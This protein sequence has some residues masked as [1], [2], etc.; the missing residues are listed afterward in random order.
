[1]N[2]GIGRS[3]ALILLLSTILA[4]CGAA[5]DALDDLLGGDDETAVVAD[6][7]LAEAID[8]IEAFWAEQGPLVELDYEPVDRDRIL[9]RSELDDIGPAECSFDGGTDDLTAES[10]ADNAYVIE[11][12]E[13]NTV[14]LDDVDYVPDLRARYG[15]AGP[16][17]LV[18]HE[19]G[20]VVQNQL[21]RTEQTSILAEQQAD[22]YSGAYI[23][24]AES[25]GRAPFDD[26]ASL[27]DAILSTIETADGEEVTASDEEAHGNGFDRV[28]ATQEGYDRGV[29]FCAA[30]DQNPPPVTQIGFAA[31]DTSGNLPFE[32]ADRSLLAEVAFYFDSVAADYVDDPDPAA[33]LA[34]T[35]VLPGEEFLQDLYDVIGDNA[36]GAQYALAY[37]EALQ[38]LV[39]DPTT[40]DGAALQRACLMGSW[41]HDTLEQGSNAS[42]GALSPGDIDEA[43]L[44]YLVSPDLDDQPGLIFE[45]LASLRLG[46]VEGV[47]ACA[48]GR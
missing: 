17:V 18:A 16:A 34:E 21:G 4:A 44:V 47:D 13:G 24:W 28:R 3:T 23:A 48:V 39:G 10:V 40:G 36:I 22:C 14:V 12:D 30:Y 46:T 6:P 37:G 15:E 45:L 25:G 35:V 43:M 27:D 42:A 32:E 9:L 29:A 38:K 5:E 2:A 7:R 31:G 20:H 26:P 19:W 11:C 41:L 1:M 8:D 33:A